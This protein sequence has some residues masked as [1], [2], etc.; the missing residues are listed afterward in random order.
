[1]TSTP[2]S[3]VISYDIGCQ[4]HKNLSKRIEQYGSELAPSIKPDKVIVLFLKFHLP[5]HISDCQEEFS[6]K[7]EPNVGATDGKVLEQGWAASNLIAS[8]TKEMGPGSRHDTLDDHW[9]DNN[10]RKCVNMG[11]N[12]ECPN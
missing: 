12:S 4:W 9:G 5:A 7:L 2:K 6:F 8:S 11:T 1:M 3:V 10:W